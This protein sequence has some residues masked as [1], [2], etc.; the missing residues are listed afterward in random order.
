MSGRGNASTVR[1]QA[2][3]HEWLSKQQERAKRPRPA[4]HEIGRLPTLVTD[5]LSAGT[6]VATPSPVSVH[7]GAGAGAGAGGRGTTR[8]QLADTR[9][10]AAS[11]G[12]AAASASKKRR[13]HY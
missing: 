8:N 11:S 12:G 7:T 5:S 13:Q 3:R 9:R 2:L 1:L 10:A 4:A 6:P